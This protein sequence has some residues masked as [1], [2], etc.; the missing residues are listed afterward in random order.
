VNA[1]IEGFRPSVSGFRFANAFASEAA[2]RLGPI[3]VGNAANGLCGGMVLAALD[4]W[5]AR[6]APPS[7]VEPPRAG[8]PM[9]DYLL[10][11]LIASWDLPFGGLRYLVWQSMTAGAL[12]ERTAREWE[13][14]RARLDRGEPVPLGVIRVHSLDPVRVGENHQLLSYGYE[15]SSDRGV[16]VFVYDPNHPF[17]DDLVLRFDPRA[18]S[19]IDYL[20]GEAP[21][22]GF[23][24]VRYRWRDP[25][26]LY[27][28]R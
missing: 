10:R 5:I 26:P 7:D 15:P 1:P 20:D 8:T 12:G 28:A 16:R 17:R 25:A 2:L 4:L 3:P 9:F 24:V 23:F 21:V 27:G 18:A 14:V 13:V 6:M 19:S 11:R 22:R